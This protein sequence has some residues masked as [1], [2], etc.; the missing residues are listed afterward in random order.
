MLRIRLGGVL[1]LGMIINSLKL[2]I[3]EMHVEFKKVK[4]QVNY[5]KMF[6]DLLS[7]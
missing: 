5:L 1:I 3:E 2:T 7:Q 6:V 4:C